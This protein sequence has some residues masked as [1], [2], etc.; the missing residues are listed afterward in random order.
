MFKAFFKLWLVVFIPLFFLIFPNPYSP[1]TLINEYAEKSRYINLYRGTFTLIERELKNVEPSLRQKY[2]DAISD[3]FGYQLSLT[4][5]EAIR[6]TPSQ[7]Q[8]LRRGSFVFVNSEPEQLIKSTPFDD[9]ALILE[10]DITPEED[11]VRAS[12]G[13]LL[14]IKRKFE[15]SPRQTWPKLAKDLS[16]LT[17]HQLSIELRNHLVFTQE[18]HRQKENYGFSWQSLENDSTV[19]YL[20]L[21]Q[22]DE[23]LTI[24]LI[25]SSPITASLLF[26]VLV[27]FIAV[28]SIGMFIWV[29]PLWRDLNRLTNTAVDFGKGNLTV[30]AEISKQSVIANLSKSFNGMAQKIESLV[31]GQK[32]LTDAITHDLRTPLYRLRFAF[33]MLDDSELSKQDIRR[34]RDNIQNSIDDLDH[35]ISQTLVFSRYNRSSDFFQKK[36][37]CFAHYLIEEVGHISLENS[38]ISIDLTVDESVCE[39]KIPIDLRAM[40]RVLN[41]LITN[42]IRYTNHQIKVTFTQQDGNYFLIVEDDGSG[43][44]SEYWERIFEPFSQLDDVQ[45]STNI[46]HGLGLSIV[47][48]IAQLHDGYARVS[49]SKLGGARFIVS[50]PV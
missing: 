41:N 32:D 31:K 28:I 23:V 29:S 12:K 16:E 22:T 14:L 40:L 20:P 47:Q 42:A 46:G 10:L 30:R 44:D 17:S 50:W 4:E 5:T 15:S 43:I 33:E 38:G 25:T 8:D 13:T 18:H 45:R 9:Q 21:G 36:P 39:L 24:E 11:L 35:L 27:L 34:Y 26:I 6:L 3:S 2:I 19:F 48:K 37:I 7:R 1:I 49:H